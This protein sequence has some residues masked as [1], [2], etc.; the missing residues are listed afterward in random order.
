MGN[1]NIFV[2][3]YDL[4]VSRFEVSLPINLLFSITFHLTFLFA[5]INLLSQH[6]SLLVL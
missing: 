2:Y 3:E 6:I 4:P 1:D 5:D